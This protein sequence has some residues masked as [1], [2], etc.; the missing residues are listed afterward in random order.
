MF[1][2]NFECGVTLCEE[3][4]CWRFF[5]LEL[6]FADREKICKYRKN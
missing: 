6:Y 4:F 5:S 2:Y 1:V 3:N